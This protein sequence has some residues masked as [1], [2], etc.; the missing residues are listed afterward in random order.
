MNK[1]LRINAIMIFCMFISSD[2]YS[3]VRDSSAIVKNSKNEYSVSSSLSGGITYYSNTNYLGIYTNDIVQPSISPAISYFGKS[4]LI[5][6][7][8][9]FFINN[10]DTTYNNEATEVD[11]QAGYR[12]DIN[13]HL[14][15]T[16]SYVHFFYSKNMDSMRSAFRDYFDLAINYQSKW[17]IG[18]L[19]S[20]Y[21]FGSENLIIIET[22]TGLNISLDKLIGHY[23]ILFIQPSVNLNFNNQYYYR[24]YAFIYFNFLQT[25]EAKYPGTTIGDFRLYLADNPHNGWVRAIKLYLDRHPKIDAAYDKLK[26]KTLISD[27]FKV[28]TRFNLSYIEI[29]FPVTWSFRNI[30]VKLST[31]AYRPVNTPTFV[32]SKWNVM[33]NVGLNYMFNW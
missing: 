5:F 15:L 20:A 16:P 1:A 22:Q 26:S 17:F 2:I 8:I 19:T 25:Y 23:Q 27:L 4:G 29:P 13:S 10:A 33:Y 3:Q 6:S 32:D 28:N 14:S 7:I 18:N 30:V 9:P 12:W 24:R 31:S 11:F 21:V